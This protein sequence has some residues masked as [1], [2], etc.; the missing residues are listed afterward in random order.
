MVDKWTVLGHPVYRYTFEPRTSR[1]WSSSRT[2]S[3]AMFDRWSN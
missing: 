2:H 3:T 1:I